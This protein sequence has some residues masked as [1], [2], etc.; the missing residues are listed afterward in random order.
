MRRIRST[1][2]VIALNNLLMAFGFRLWQSLFNNYS[3]EVLGVQANQIGTIQAVREIPGL[4]G[5]LVGLLALLWAEMRIAGIAIIVMG[6]GI[7]ATALAGNVAGL[8]GA[9]LLMSIG[10]HFFYSS[11]NAAVLLTA[12]KDEAPRV[13]GQLNSL[14]AVAAAVGT[15]F[16]LGTLDAW[17]YRNLY[18]I[19][20]IAVVL[21]GLALLP[22]GR[23]P[24]RKRRTRRPA[25]LRRRYWLYY[26]LQLLMGSRRHIFTT[27]A[28]FLLV[29]G[30][31]VT[32]QVITL[33]FLINNL[34][35]TYF[36]QAFGKIV[37]R[38]GERRVLSINFTLLTFVFLGYAVIPLLTVL[39]TPSLTVPAV[40][41]GPIVV[42]PAFA[43]SPALFILFG[44]FII[45][46]VL[47]G[48]S[49][50]VE[51][52]FQ[53]IVV[54][55]EEI[56]A[57]TSFG[58]TINHIPAVIVPLVGG[59]IWAAAGAQYTFLAGVVIALASLW[60][61]QYVRLPQPQPAGGVAAGS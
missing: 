45:D 1:L 33:L 20:G 29:Q 13:L 31:A 27:F 7:V 57:N 49:I 37:A 18:L 41:I 51:S 54:G 38:F 15:L 48:F 30:Y 56:T 53:K 4:V 28:V 43:A 34:V 19:G 26:T 40:S 58:Q 42:F 36:N 8:V 6:L 46:N 5:F 14:G 3:V 35:G 55:P 25:P 39:E 60:L 61:A 11:N 2:A 16:I 12:G 52:Y 24:A 59:M 10:F 44:L 17:G 50:A 21:G 23:Q 22:F 9:T 32:A 47:F